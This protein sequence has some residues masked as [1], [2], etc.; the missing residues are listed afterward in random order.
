[1]TLPRVGITPGDPGGIGPEIVLKSLGRMSD[2]P[3]AEYVLFCSAD[4]LKQEAKKLKLP[5][6]LSAPEKARGS[7]NRCLTIKEIPFPP[8]SGRKGLPSGANG[9]ASFRCFETAV[10]EA[11]EGW[12]Q[13]LVT[14]PISKASWALAGI[15]WKG[16][17]D[18]LEKLYP[19]AIMAFWSEKLKVAL[20]SHHVSLRRALKKVTR[21][22]LV[23]F[24]LSLDRSLKKALPGGVEFL[25]AGL[26]PHAG[27]ERLMGDE[28]EREII[29]AIR[30]AKRRGLAVS[31]PYPPDVAFRVALGKKNA[32]AVALY[33]DQG[34]I[35]FKLIAFEVGVNVSLGLPFSRTSPDHG[36]AFDIAGKNQADARSFLEAVRLAVALAPAGTRT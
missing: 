29:P 23:G 8:G 13:A 33:H 9:L 34:L 2:L 18:Y 25:V 30:E 21:E 3:E 7:R 4:F 24:L 10:R 12:L 31:G 19:G 26:N 36:T 27:E 35:P 14:A 15:R 22:N 11:G 5:F 6:P 32:V 20:L 1:M 17:T 16:H 28:E